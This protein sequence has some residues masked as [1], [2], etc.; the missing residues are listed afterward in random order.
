M[1]EAIKAANYE[2]NRTQQVFK[3]YLDQF[4]ASLA[5]EDGYARNTVAAYRNDLSQLIEYLGTPRTARSVS[6]ADVTS[7]DLAAFVESLRYDEN[8]Q[9]QR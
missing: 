2:R 9:A 6:W 4:L 7:A 8:C 1:R 3:S 5:H